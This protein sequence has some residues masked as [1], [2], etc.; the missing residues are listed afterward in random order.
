M[1]V[2]RNHLSLH[3]HLSGSRL[4]LLKKSWV[5]SFLCWRTT[6]VVCPDR[7]CHFIFI[8]CAGARPCFSPFMFDDWSFLIF[9]WIVIRF[10]PFIGEYL[11]FEWPKKRYQKKSHPTVL[12]FGCSVR[13]SVE[14]ALRNSLRSDSPRAIPL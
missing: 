12:A 11:F 7:A 2:D 14:R 10:S 4:L 1:I 13:F 6:G 9:D 3:D 5:F 8:Y